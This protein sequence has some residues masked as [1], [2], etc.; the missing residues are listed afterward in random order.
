MDGM[1]LSIG[2]REFTVLPLN[3]RGLRRLTKAGVMKKLGE[4]SANPLG[5][6]EPQIDAVVAFAH[7]MLVRAHPELT[8]DEVEDMIEVWDMPRLIPQLMSGAGLG[9]GADKGEA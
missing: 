1:K 6:E 8:L 3:L 7:A 5:L 2:P 4:M 9:G